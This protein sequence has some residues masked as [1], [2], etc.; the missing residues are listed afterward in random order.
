MEHDRGKPR[1]EATEGAAKPADPAKFSPEQGSSAA[2]KPSAS[3]KPGGGNARGESPEA[4]NQ[5]PGKM[6]AERLRCITQAA[7]KGWDFATPPAV[8]PPGD[9][10][11]ALSQFAGR[12]GGTGSGRIAPRSGCF[13]GGNRGGIG[14]IDSI[15]GSFGP[16]GVGR[17]PVV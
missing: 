16:A 6:G 9:P 5:K 17:V 14:P 8:W 10:W 4:S 12:P 15:E 2:G 11:W 7:C 13:S 3:G 1:G